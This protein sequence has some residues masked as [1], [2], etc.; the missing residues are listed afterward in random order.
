MT[1]RFSETWC[2]QCGT[3]FG[4]GDHGFSHCDTHPGWKR[5]RKLRRQAAARKAA[6]TRKRRKGGSL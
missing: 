2:S 1:P 6:E 4:P 5:D 3:G